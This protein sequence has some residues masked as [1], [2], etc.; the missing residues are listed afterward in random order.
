MRRRKTRART[1]RWRSPPRRFHGV[2]ISEKAIATARE[3]PKKENL[4]LTYEVADLNFLELPDNTFDLV[5]A[6]TS[7]ITSFFL[8]E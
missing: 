1:R 3:I 8:S 5:V 4:S 7:P 2:D 6:Q